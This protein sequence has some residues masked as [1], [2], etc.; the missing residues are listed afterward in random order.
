MSKKKAAKVGTILL[1]DDGLWW[2]YG[3]Y[4]TNEGA[5][6]NIGAEKLVTILSILNDAEVDIKKEAERRLKDE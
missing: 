4:P 3:I 2:Y 1:G 5:T 6:V